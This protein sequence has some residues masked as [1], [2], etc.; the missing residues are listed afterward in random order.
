VRGAAGLAADALAAVSGWAMGAVLAALV[1]L[2]VA[3][4]VLRYGLGLGWPWAGDLSIIGLLTLAWLG[5]GHLWLRGAHIAV[6]LLPPGASR[7]AG[8]AFAL[9]ALAASV[10]ALP[11]TWEAVRL[12][13]AIDLAALPLPMA[14]KYVPV[15]GGLVWLIAAVLLRAAAGR[16]ARPT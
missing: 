2:D 13:A 12:Y 6:D 9:A 7:G 14:A 3:Q 5:A 11:M 15:L 16:E 10:V 8:A 1:A 4:V